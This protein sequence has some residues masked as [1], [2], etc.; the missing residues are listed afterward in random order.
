[1]EQGN[2]VLV[3]GSINTDLVVRTRRAPEAG[4]T[5]TGTSF[6]TFGGGKGANQAVATARAGG[7][8]AML[9]G[10]GDDDFGRQRLLDLE[11]ESVAIST[12]VRTT[13]ASSGVALITVEDS[14][15]NR[16]AYVPGAGWE[17]TPDD[18]LAAL[19]AWSPNIVLSTLELRP[20]TLDTLFRAAKERG[21][22]IVCNA[23][24]E[25]SEGRSLLALADV[26]IVNEQEAAELAGTDAGGDWA[27]F[28]QRLA[29]MGPAT[30]I[31]TLGSS[32]ALVWHDGNVTEVPTIAVD[33][34]DT[35]GAGDAF[36]GAFTALLSAGASAE[37]AAAK[38]VIAGSL[39][40]S[41]AGAQPSIATR[42]EIDSA[43]D[44]R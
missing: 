26:L 25:P 9:G 34:V 11:A 15:Q 33:V 7:Q 32:G 44:S 42:E 5:V 39:A 36:S 30:V 31:L 35:T 40:V 43:F 16:I 8:V 37:E 3:A 10:V 24:P 21:I 22:T 29:K 41:K 27:S 20:K 13:S 28:A 12:I 19:E 18:A 38:A 6:A 1:L 23:T 2:R 14:G 17:V 4:E